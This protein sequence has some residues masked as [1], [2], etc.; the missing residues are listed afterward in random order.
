MTI[1]SKLTHN[2][3]KPLEL[4]APNLHKTVINLLKKINPPR[5]HKVLDAGA[6]QGALSSELVKLGFK[7]LACDIDN[8]QFLIP[9]V[10]CQKA[11][12]NKKLPYSDNAF[13][14]VVSLETI[15]HLENPWHFIREAKRLLKKDG[16]L[17]LSTPNVSHI[18]S[19]LLFL[20]TGRLFMFWPDRYLKFNWHINPVFS[21]EL[22]FI[23]ENLGFRFIEE[24]YNEGKII[25]LFRPFFKN[26][27]L[28]FGSPLS[29][30]YLPK[31]SLFGENLIIIARKI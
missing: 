16:L 7:V 25:P 4:A 9:G 12:L 17:I 26:G 8:S 28:F 31:N 21:W 11:D 5:N 15:E 10:E 29:L 6:G 18:S 19:R 14:I 24:K 27:K 22:K 30:S 3:P 23:F 2:S 13:D 20:L 1:V